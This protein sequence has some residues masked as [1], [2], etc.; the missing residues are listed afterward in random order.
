MLGLEVFIGGSTSVICQ[1][2]RSFE[3]EKS[4]LGKERVA[5]ET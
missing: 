1:G 5:A 3:D 4:D 2:V